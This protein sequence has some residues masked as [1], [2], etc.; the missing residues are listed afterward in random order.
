MKLMKITRAN[1]LIVNLFYSLPIAA[2]VIQLLH[3][4]LTECHSFFF[5]QRFSTKNFNSFIKT[6]ITK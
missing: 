5:C 4:L 3:N 2:L 6:S 1:S